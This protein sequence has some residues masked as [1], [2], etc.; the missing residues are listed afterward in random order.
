MTTI[1]GPGGYYRHSPSALNLF[2]AAPAMFVL[3]KILG[4]KQVVGVPAHR[5]V[6]VEAG[7]A[8]GL[9][10]PEADESDCFKIAYATYDTLTA[11]SGDERRE[12]YRGNIPDMVTTAL[13]E[14]RPYGKPT[15][16]QGAVTWHPE[17]LTYPVFGYYDFLWEET[18]IVVDLKTT[19]RM[20]S[21]IKVPHAR[22]VALYCGDNHDGRITYCTPKKVATYALENIREHR[23]ALHN[24]ARK[25]EAFL[26][27][28]NDPEFFVSIT[29]PDLESFYWGDPAVRE[30]AFKHWGI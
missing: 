27:L 29:V 6:A 14:L 17:D 13:D 23:N 30:L 24:M 22:Q 21:S 11:M 8:H 19:E 28:G 10:N 3:E 7:V 2:A 12:K 15:N 4:L 9:N 18:G 5:G 26:A 16:M 25:V 1:T 20:P